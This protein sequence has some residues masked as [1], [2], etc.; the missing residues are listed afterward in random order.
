MIHRAI[1]RTFTRSAIGLACAIAAVAAHRAAAANALGRDDEAVV[2]DGSSIPSLQGIR[3][4]RLVA[5]RYNAGWTAIPV[6][7]DERAVVPFATI[8]NTASTAGSILTYTDPG[9]FT[10]ADPDVTLDG[11]DEIALRA[12]DAGARAPAAAPPFGTLAGTGVELA[13]TNPLNGSVAWIYLFE[14]DGSLDPSAGVPPIGYV[15][16]L[17][18][19]DYKT[20][21]GTGNGPNPEN[22]TVTTGSYAVHFSDRWIRD[23]MAMT[24]GGATGVD[25]LDRQ[26][27]LFGPGDCQRSEKTFSDGEG[28]FIVNRAGPVRALRGYVGAN[29]GVTTYR[30]HTF[31]AA[32]EAIFTALRVHP[33]PGVMDYFDYS[34]AAAGMVYR[35]DL[36]TVGVAI[37]G[38]PDTVTAGELTW[39]MVTGLQ[40][41]LVSTMLLHTDIP[42]F[43]ST[44]YYSDT[45]QPTTTQCTGD[46]FEY[47]ASGFWRDAGIP[48]TDPNLGTA[49]VFE[50]TRVLRYAAPNQSLAFAQ[51]RA[52]E[53]QTPMTVAAAPL[54]ACPD[55][56]GDGYAVCA[57]A[58][59]LP[60]GKTCGDCDDTRPSVH[61]GATEA[62]GNGLDDDCNG[63]TDA[64]DPACAL[65]P[66]PDADSDGFAVCSASCSL[67]P[68]K[69]CGDCDDT[70]AGVH[71]G[72]TEVCNGLDDN[73]NG[74]I[75]ERA[76][77]TFYRDA[78]G[79]GFGNPA[80]TTQACAVPAGYVANATDCDDTKASV[81][82]GVV[83]VCN[84]IDDNC[85]GTI[86]EGVQ[87]TFYRDADG[88][89]FGNAGSTTQACSVPAGY[90]ANATDCDD[91]KASVHPGATEVCNGIDD[92]CNGTIDEGVQTTFYRDADGDGFGNA[93]STTQGCSAPAGYVV[94]S[95]DCD[96]TRASVHPGATEACGNGLDDDCNGLADAT[97]PACALP[98]CP[99]ADGDGYALCS[100]SCSLPAAKT[101]G[102]CDDTK[103]SVHPGATE[104]CGN[105]ID[106]DC[107]GF[108][109]GCAPSPC[110]DADGDGYAVC[111]DACVA[112]PGTV[113][114]DCD[115]TR[116][117]VHPGSAESCNGLD[118]NC[119]GTIDEGVQTTFYRDADADG[120][121]SSSVTVKACSAPTGYVL[122]STDCDDTRATVHPNAPELCGNGIDDDCSGTTDVAFCQS[123]DTGGDGRVDGLDLGVLGRAFGACSA[124]PESEWWS[125][126]DYDRDGCVDGADLALL[127]TAWACHAGEDVCHP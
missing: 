46:A 44:S 43:T 10:G 59:T 63:L 127:A 21:Y 111:S 120:Y 84:G 22:S 125:A 124:N 75:D 11:D 37:D 86:D 36:N 97:D 51:A 39:E 76:Q 126:V 115:D 99:D 34:P 6:Q 13:I 40:G 110:P 85:N 52:A 118:D 17:L 61:P 19:G 16:D 122:D 25:V 49:A 54:P 48:N 92:N 62:C 35:N 83:E 65:P 119:D 24:A 38:S 96:D 90:V 50:M 60:A 31:Y 121:G 55:A 93:G 56:D 123:F 18:S 45:T 72:A 53:A 102:D 4:T 112:A 94:N 66:C 14:S 68:A 79:D 42:S 87:T 5:F 30:I 1:V 98:P 80:S 101:C 23:A 107:D 89:G 104:I 117:S 27:M 95:T 70:N 33:I 3:P 71:P 105:G 57:T 106:D 91:T 116:A 73:C 74:T 2:L 77:L 81:H 7:V 69:S 88:D 41:T 67:P 29:S 109:L 12:S 64:A 28:A 108:D 32:E 8:Y 9:T 20:T 103:A 26:K 113:C 47:G 15:F 82:P 58:C 78:D 100:A 114:G